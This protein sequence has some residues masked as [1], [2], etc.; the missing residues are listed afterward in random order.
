MVIE[1]AEDV[2]ELEIRSGMGDINPLEWDALIGADDQPF[3]RHAFLSTL[4]D[5]GSL[6]R[7][8]GWS[9]MPLLL[10][11][12]GISIAAA[13]GYLK[14]NSHGEFVFDWSWAN[15]YQRNGLH[16]YPKL[17]IG[18]PYSPIPG[19][20]LLVGD[21]HDANAR[22]HLL[23]RAV[24][25]LVKQTKLSSVHINFARDAD[26]A[27][28]AADPWL[29]RFDWQY[30]WS[31]LGYRDFD[32]FLSV[33]NA[34]KRKNI[35]QERAQ[36]ASHG[37]DISWDDASALS[38]HDL[39]QIHALYASTFERKHNTAALTRT[40]F[41]LLAERF[42]QQFHVCLARLDRTIVAA[43]V[44]FSS[45]TTLYGRYWGALDDWSGLHFELCYYR[46][47]EWAIANGKSRFE[48]G[49]QGEHKIARGFLA[50]RTRSMHHIAHAGF[51]RAIRAS[52]DEEAQSLREYRLELDAKSPYRLPSGCD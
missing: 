19:A 10:R 26:A 36:S 4:E 7:E 16:Y 9:P 35:R 38:E 40:C 30:H 2:C 41:S 32:D 46:G 11:R 25:Q 13:P 44:F 23:Q 18:V 1:D 42:P 3:L 14:G 28:C 6:Q 43:A 45:S 52:L 22:R 50:T 15:A 5:S 47:I 33:L 20:R 29:P 49:A 34:K 51:R 24:L 27:A 17:L 21:G 48:P 8:L 39:D 12:D 31:N 37:F